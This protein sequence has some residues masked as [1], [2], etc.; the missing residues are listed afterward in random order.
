MNKN[1]YW[2]GIRKSEIE[3]SNNFFKD[4]VV[5]FGKKN[6][7]SIQSLTSFLEKNI[8]LNDSYNDQMITKYHKES[9]SINVQLMISKNEVFIF[10]GSIQLIEKQHNHLAYKGCDFIS[11]RKIK[12]KLREKAENYSQ[13]I[14]KDLQKR[15]YLGIC[16]ID[17]LIYN[18]EVYFMEINSRFQSSSTVLN[19]ALK[20]NNIYSLQEMNYMCFNNMIINFPSIDINYSSYIIDYEDESSYYLQDKPIDILDEP[21][22]NL[23]FEK[24]SYWKTLLYDKE[25][26]KGNSYE[27]I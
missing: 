1:K 23:N 27:I 3:Y 19:K 11:F 9:V 14:G 12:S 16:G 6:N 21:D 5:V 7:N 15:G 20:D 26:F 24:R 13:I 4:S 18:D 2:I 25:L 8:D 22:I 17:F 10:P